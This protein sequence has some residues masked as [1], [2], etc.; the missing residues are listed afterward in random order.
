[1]LAKTK[2]PETLRSL[3]LHNDDLVVQPS[4]QS[5]AVPSHQSPAFAGYRSFSGASRI[6]FRTASVLNLPAVLLE[7]SLRLSPVFDPLLLPSISFRLP[8]ALNLRAVPPKSPPGLRLVLISSVPVDLVPACAVSRPSGL[9]PSLPPACAGLRSLWLPSI[10]FRLPWVFDLRAVPSKSLSGFH[11]VFNFFGCRQSPSNFC[12]VAIF[13]RR[14]PDSLCPGFRRAFDSL[15][16]F[17]A[18]FR[19]AS[20]LYSSGGALHLHPTFYGG[21]QLRRTLGLASLWTQ[22]GKL[23][24]NVDSF[25]GRGWRD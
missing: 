23:V 1:M 14:T 16:A 15:A 19:L 5:L 21:H 20:N 7:L 17:R 3:A 24:T 6:N 13:L 2:T 8:S 25:W 9:P 18:S 11:R 12:R 4:V 10:S 22:S